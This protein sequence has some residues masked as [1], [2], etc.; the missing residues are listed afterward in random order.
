MEKEV[1]TQV[2]KIA[3]WKLSKMTTQTKESFF[4]ENIEEI[5]TKKITD[6]FWEILLLNTP[7]SVVENIISA[8]INYI[9]LWENPNADGLWVITSYHKSLDTL[10]ESF[11]TK[12]FRKYAK[13]K[14][15]IQLR[16]NDVLE[17]SLNSVV[18]TWYILSVWRLYHLITI[19]VNEEELFDYGKCF[20]E[21]LEK[22]ESISNILLDED[23][24]INF[25]KLVD[26]EI[27]WKKR[28]IWKISFEE[29]KEARKLLIWDFKDQ[30][31]LI[32]KFIEIAKMEY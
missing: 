12:W 5:I 28:H 3:K 7:S 4:S 22:Y 17:K 26:S 19:I 1:R 24:I 29:A 8:E 30:N 31:C 11:V 18:N 14:W 20:K 13:K 2:K 23:F 6:F 21:Y 25:K 9:N 16:R 27:L 10:I 15:Q 32:Y